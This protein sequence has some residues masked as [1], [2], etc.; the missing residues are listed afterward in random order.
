MAPATS[1]EGLLDSQQTNRKVPLK[2]ILQNFLNHVESLETRKREGEDAYEKEFQSLKLFSDHLKS[3]EDFTCSE[4]EKDVNR[5]KNRY[6]DILPFDY[7]RVALSEYP[8]VP[9]SDYMNAN[10]IKGASGSNA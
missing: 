2:T 3:Q 6:K 4:G 10:F 7:S 1:S 9:G 8:G 5:K